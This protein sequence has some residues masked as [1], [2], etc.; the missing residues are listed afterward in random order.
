MNDSPFFGPLSESVRS[1][2]QSI[3]KTAREFLAAEVP[4]ARAEAQLE[5]VSDAP[6]EQDIT[7]EE[8][9]SKGQ[10]RQL[11][12]SYVRE[13]TDVRRALSKLGFLRRS[14]EQLRAD[15][16]WNIG[17]LYDSARDEDLGDINRF[18]D[19]FER[20]DPTEGEDASIRRLIAYLEELL[21]PDSRERRNSL[22]EA[23]VGRGIKHLAGRTNA[24]LS[25]QLTVLQ[26][27]QLS[28]K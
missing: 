28:E 16:H 3:L 1:C 24:E 15:L 4:I 8:L 7:G 9:L 17:G 19:Q 2:V 5:D 26:A 22:L 6:S 11:C 13:N 20:V 21:V 23:L 14:K 18:I 12:A 10:Q 25:Q 27:R